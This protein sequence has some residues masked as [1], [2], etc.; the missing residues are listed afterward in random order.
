MNKEGKFSTVL[1]R[2]DLEWTSNTKL[3]VKIL[4]HIDLLSYSKRGDVR[5]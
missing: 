4:R 1:T 3:K 2:K 5:V